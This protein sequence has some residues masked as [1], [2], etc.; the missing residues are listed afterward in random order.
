VV[1]QPADE[2]VRDFVRDVPRSHV[3]TAGGIMTA[4]L[5]TNDTSGTVAATTPVSELVAMVVATDKPIAVLDDDG[6]ICGS[7][8]RLAVLRALAE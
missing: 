5:S 6:S 8:D 7:V 4:A 3:L 1:A 2:Y